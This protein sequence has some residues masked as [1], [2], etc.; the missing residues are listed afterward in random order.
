[1][2]IAESLGIFILT[3]VLVVW[4]P[5]NL[6]IGWIA[7]LGAAASLALGTI[8][9]SAVKT[10]LGLVWDATLTFVAVIVITTVLD[11]IGF[12]EWAALHMAHAARGSGRRVFLYVV[13][14]GAVVAAFFN[15]DGAALILTPIVLEKM[16]LLRWERRVMVP[17]AMAGG[18]IADAASLP[19]VVSNLVNIVS[20]DVFH[21]GFLDYALKMALP[22]VVSVAAST[23]VLWAVFARDIPVSYDPGTLSRPEH[24]LRDGV[25]FRLAWGLLVVLMAGYILTQPL[26]LPV[27]VVATLVA[28]IFLA[29][30]SSRGLIRPWQVVREAPWSI[31]AFSMGMYLVV[32]GLQNAGLIHLL[33]Q[34]LVWAAEG[35]GLAAILATGFLAA[36]GSSVMNNL[37]MVMVGALA[38]HAARVSPGVHQAMVYANVIGCDLGPKLTP[39]GSLATLLWLRVLAQ[40]GVVVGWATYVKTGVMLT[41]PTLL[42]TLLALYW[43]LG[44]V[45]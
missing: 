30:G 22:D 14:L 45:G 31:V 32:Y 21:I 11:R 29:A 16:R 33:A 17:F 43:W 37:P 27:S 40:K 26:H 35:G 4:R 38:V 7:I 13:L 39:I 15:N 20:A 3:L 12:F 19:L 24:A 8:S 36:L 5:R 42:V 28:A 44:V 6:S 18:F 2:K 1:M 41:L 23:A 10:V 25:M 34:T 9:L